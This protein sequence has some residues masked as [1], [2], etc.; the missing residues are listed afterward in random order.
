[1]EE[2]ERERERERTEK[3]PHSRPDTPRVQ[4]NREHAQEPE[5]RDM[6]SMSKTSCRGPRERERG[7]KAEKER[8]KER[9]RE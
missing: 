9:E 3:K 8:E 1:M 7:K 5:Y 6:T 4:G 2:R